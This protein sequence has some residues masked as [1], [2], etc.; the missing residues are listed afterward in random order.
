MTAVDPPNVAPA[1][2]GVQDLRQLLPTSHDELRALARCLLGRGR[3]PTL[4]TTS[5]VHEAWLKLARHGEIAVRGHDHFLAL[6]ATAMRHV[7]VDDARRRRAAKRGGGRRAETL[8]ERSAT[9]AR[10]EV[11]LIALDQALGRLAALDPRKARLVELRFFGGLGLDETAAALGVSRST[12]KREWRMAKAWLRR[13]I[14]GEP[15]EARPA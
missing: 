3:A 11:D 1:P 9:S 4:R 6:A 7:L 5:L 13:E 14:G 10:D 12:V 2:A 15:G 8:D